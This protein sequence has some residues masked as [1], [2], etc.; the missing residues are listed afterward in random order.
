MI[1]LLKRCLGEFL[2][3]IGRRLVR[4][5]DRDQYIRYT[6]TNSRNKYNW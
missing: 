6:R 5:S 4:S 3:D 2:I 1:E